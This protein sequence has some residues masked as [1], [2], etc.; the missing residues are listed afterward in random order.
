MKDHLLALMDWLLPVV[1]RW[2]RREVGPRLSAMLSA[3]WFLQL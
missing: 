2:V 3:S 1:L